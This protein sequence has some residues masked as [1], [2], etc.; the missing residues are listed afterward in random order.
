MIQGNETTALLYTV[1]TNFL[2][3]EA[4]AAN[5]LNPVEILD[6]NSGIITLLSP[7][8]RTYVR[9]KTADEAD[10]AIVGRVSG[11]PMPPDGSR[12]GIGPKSIPVAPPM[13]AMPNLPGA[14]ATLKMPAMPAMPPIPMMSMPGEKLELRDTGQKT[15]LLGFVCTHYELKQGGETMDI[16]ATDQLLPYQPYLQHQPHRYGLGRIE[17]KWPGMLKSRRLFPLL[18]TLGY[19]NGVAFFRFQLQSVTPQNL[20]VDDARLFQP[21]AGW[22][23]IQPPPF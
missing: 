11:M 13:P 23:E 7:N 6:L 10:P 22:N 1:E 8:N 21:P 19:D 2:R 17:E 5:R 20:T 15:N 4:N 16:W 9:F 14:P 3:V 12:P 18:A